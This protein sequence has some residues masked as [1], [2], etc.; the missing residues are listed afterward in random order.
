MVFA[1]SATTAE[2]AATIQLTGP[3]H[4]TVRRIAFSLFAEQAVCM[5]YCPD[6]W[7]KK[8]DMTSGSAIVKK[9]C[10]PP[11]IDNISILPFAA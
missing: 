7:Q 9:C 6:I 2:V 3:T 8:F 4:H 11:V 1:T 5:R 10:I